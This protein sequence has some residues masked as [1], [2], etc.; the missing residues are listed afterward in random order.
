MPFRVERVPSDI[1]S[2]LSRGVKVSVQYW[3][4]IPYNLFEL[5]LTKRLFH[6]TESSWTDVW[7]GNIEGSEIPNVSEHVSSQICRRIVETTL[8]ACME[9]GN[10]FFFRFVLFCFDGEDSHIWSQSEIFWFDFYCW[11]VCFFFKAEL[12]WLRV[13]LIGSACVWT[14]RFQGGRRDNLNLQTKPRKIASRD[15]KVVNFSNRCLF[16]SKAATCAGMSDSEIEDALQRSTTQEV[17]E[18]LKATTAEACEKGVCVPEKTHIL[19]FD[20][21]LFTANHFPYLSTNKFFTFCFRHLVRR[22][23]LLR[24][25]MAKSI[26]FLA[27][28]GWKLLPSC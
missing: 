2:R 20:F 6:L 8:A 12:V 25:L 11:I 19:K 7:K 10:K 3:T 15:R 1:T 28:T 26:W 22:P 21:S 9:Q 23:W 17:K 14:G 18:Q 27:L 4:G 16:L 13:F 24:E 5:T